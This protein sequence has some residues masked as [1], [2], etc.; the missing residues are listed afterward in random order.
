[1]NLG[2]LKYAE[3][4]HHRRKKIAR[5]DASG[6]G[7]T[8]GKGHKGQMSR[9]GAKHRAW[10]EG[11]QMPIQRR[12][13][14][15]GFTNIHREENQIV[16]LTMLEALEGGLVSPDTLLAAG[17]ID[18]MN[19]PV[20]VLCDGELKAKLTVSGVKVSKS[21]QARIE[22]AGGSVQPIEG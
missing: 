16:Q 19:A 10:F 15:R 13:P 22:A 17:L 3:G 20:K 6:H 9:S 4:S 1:M 14:K 18:R 7:G 12:L 8:A 21:A 11:G 5:G 2:S